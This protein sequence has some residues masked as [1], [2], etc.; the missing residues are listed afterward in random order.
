MLKP[1]KRIIQPNEE[2]RASLARRKNQAKRNLY[3]EISTLAILLSQQQ[4]EINETNKRFA[5]LLDVV[6]TALNI[7]VGI[8]EE[9]PVEDVTENEI[10]NTEGQ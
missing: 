6:R 5:Q 2:E 8:D 4:G 7:N 10:D 1:L 3:D 9:G